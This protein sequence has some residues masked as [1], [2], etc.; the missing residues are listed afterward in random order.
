MGGGGMAGVGAGAGAGM[1]LCAAAVFIYRRKLARSA[2]GVAQKVRSTLSNPTKPRLKTQPSDLARGQSSPGR[3]WRAAVPGTKRQSSY[4]N[5]GE[6]NLGALAGGGGANGLPPNWSEAVD[7]QGVPY[8]YSD[9]GE[10]TYERPPPAAG[11]PSLPALPKKKTAAAAGSLPAA[12]GHAKWGVYTQPPGPSLPSGWEEHAADD[13]TPYYYNTTSG[14]NSW[15]RPSNKNNSSYSQPPQKPAAPKPVA[16][17][18]PKFSRPGV[19]AAAL[20]P[21]KPPTLPAGMGGP[22]PYAPQ[23]RQ[24]MGAPATHAGA[25]P[26]L[27]GRAGG[28]P[29]LPGGAG[30]S[31]GPRCGSL[32]LGGLISGQM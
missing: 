18:A 24:W 21:V 2:S 17:A 8:Y 26:P 19:A 5:L 6:L 10:S 30:P 15:E 28:P 7:D 31:A 29:P 32:G 27:P 20:L 23:S 16:A 1:A 3:S 4:K 11:S 25:P 13:G 22:P 9:Q 14:E 12:P